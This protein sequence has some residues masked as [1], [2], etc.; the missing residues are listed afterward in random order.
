MDWKGEIPLLPKRDGHYSFSNLP[1]YV[2]GDPARQLPFPRIP[3]Y[4]LIAVKKGAGFGG[5]C[6]DPCENHNNEPIPLHPEHRIGGSVLDEDGR[7]LANAVVLIGSVEVPGK[8]GGMMRFWFGD[9]FPERGLAV[10]KRVPAPLFCLTDNEG[11][12]TLT[13]LPSLDK[14]TLVAHAPGY[15]PEYAQDAGARGE[16]SIRMK[17]ILSLQGRLLIAGTEVPLGGVAMELHSPSQDRTGRAAEYVGP[18]GAFKFERLKRGACQLRIVG[19]DYR[20][21]SDR[22]ELTRENLAQ[23]LVLHARKVKTD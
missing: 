9:L 20:L 6:V 4:T 11:R 13:G 22:I 7:P 3:S 18:D 8:S 5:V 17:E 16:L 1:G 23:T 21:E 15:F 14:L 10:A 19:P 12:F 2:P